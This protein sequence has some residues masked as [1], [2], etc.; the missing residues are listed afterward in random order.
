LRPE[1]NNPCIVFKTIPF[2]QSGGIS[3]SKQAARMEMKNPEPEPLKL[4]EK[5]QNM[6]GAGRA[7]I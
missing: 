2:E 6:P 4:P 5:H 1:T 3:G 7:R